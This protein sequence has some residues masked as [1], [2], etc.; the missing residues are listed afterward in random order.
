MADASQDSLASYRSNMDEDL[1]DSQMEQAAQAAIA[2]DPDGDRLHDALAVSAEVEAGAEEPAA[3]AGVEEPAVDMDATGK[4]DSSAGDSS[5]EEDDE[6]DA[7][8]THRRLLLELMESVKE[9]GYIIN[10]PAANFYLENKELLDEAGYTYEHL[11][12][13]GSK[14]INKGAIVNAVKEIETEKNETI[15]DAQHPAGPSTQE[16]DY[17]ASQI[18]DDDDHDYVGT[19]KTLDNMSVK[20]LSEILATKE[21]EKELLESELESH[22]VKS[23]LKV[24]ADEKKAAD[25]VNSGKVTIDKMKAILPTFDKSLTAPE[26]N[27]LAKLC[28]AMARKMELPAIITSIKSELETIESARDQAE[29]VQMK[30]KRGV[31]DEKAKDAAKRKLAA[32]STSRAVSMEKTKE[33]AKRKLEAE[34]MKQRKK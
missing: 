8:I 3:N 11:V 19:E 14:K 10:E 13:E 15:L 7:Y 28:T 6:E 31:K 17:F 9:A 29:L 30:A 33:A 24:F 4:N 20:E 23:I 21:A 26:F 25:E 22:P 12:K 34:Q 5:E 27:L 18:D 1:T 16:E 2:A 32:G